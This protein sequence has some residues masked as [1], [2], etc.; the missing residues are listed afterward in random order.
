MAKNLQLQAFGERVRNLRTSREL[1]QEDL[2][3]LA[4]MHRNY[5]GGIERG[6]RNITLLN[7]IRLAK[8][9]EIS[10]SEFLRGIE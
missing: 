5:I 4:G 2:A 3:E 10:P 8:A 1:S 7:L 9:L 6:E